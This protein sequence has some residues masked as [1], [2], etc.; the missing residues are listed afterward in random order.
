MLAVLLTSTVNASNNR[1][2]VSLSNQ[3]CTIQPILINLHPN[4]YISYYP[5]AVNIDRCTA[6]C[7]NL[8]DL[9]NSVCVQNKTDDLN[10]NVFN[11]ITRIIESKILTK[12]VSFK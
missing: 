10:L 8:N 1:K 7:N 2:C 9:S 11:M 3:Q 6:S 4:E 5:F 12:H